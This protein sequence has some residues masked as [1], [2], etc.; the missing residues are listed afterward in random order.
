[1]SKK[2]IDSFKILELRK[3]GNSIRD[4]A[5]ITETS[6]VTVQKTLNGF[7]NLF[8]KMENVETFEKN[9]SKILTASVWKILESLNRDDLHDKATVQQLA[10]ALRALDNV[11]RLDAGKPNSIQ[12]TY[13]TVV[14]FEKVKN[15][16]E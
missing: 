7:S 13:S 10:Y 16:K 15:K 9:K 5:K 14:D 8:E 3:K 2:K 12:M 11:Q 1:M 6:P 4:I